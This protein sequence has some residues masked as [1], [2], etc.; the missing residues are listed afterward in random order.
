MENRLRI[1]VSGIR[2]I[3]GESLTPPLIIK[4]PQAFSNY[5][6]GGPIAAASD[7]R[8]SA[9]M[10]KN[11]VFAGVMSEGGAP[12]CQHVKSSGADIGF[13]QDADADRL[14]VV[15]EKGPAAGEEYSLAM[16]VD[17]FLRYK[18]R[19]PVVINLSTSRVLEDITKKRKV[20]LIR[21][22]VGEI[23]VTRGMLK[24]GAK[25]G[26]EGSVGIM[27]ADIHTCRDSFTGMAL[28][29]ESL[30][31]TRM[32]V[33]QHRAQLPDYFMIKDKIKSSFRD[34]KRFPNRVQKEFKD[35]QI[36]TQDGL[37]I[38]YPDFWLHIRPSNT[39]P[40]IRIIIEGSD[41]K[42]VQY[43]FKRI[44]EDI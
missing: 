41:K 20:N 1:T 33:S 2:G 16:A 3:V 10:V 27:A 25:I 24:Y 22:K 43:L 34:Q 19:S 36:N 13:A 38:D 9:E 6:G 37:R 8:P 31:K 26:D 42:T 29:L 17:Y 23:N 7:T 21:A 15:D 11:A 39:E 28:F 18:E 40:V 14:A 4:F 12:F 35:G 5:V 32:T 30:A 44:K